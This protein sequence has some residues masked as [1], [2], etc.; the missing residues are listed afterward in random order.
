VD[1]P[2]PDG[3]G[4]RSQLAECGTEPAGRRLGQGREAGVRPDNTVL[5]LD[6]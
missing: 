2:H 5:A 4:C 6:E 3:P 1:N